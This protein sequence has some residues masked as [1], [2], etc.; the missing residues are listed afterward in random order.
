MV[1]LLA[2][3][4][5]EGLRATDNHPAAHAFWMALRT[6]ARARY[7]EASKLHAFRTSLPSP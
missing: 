7:I 1:T 4:E 2:L 5:G 6:N 3:D